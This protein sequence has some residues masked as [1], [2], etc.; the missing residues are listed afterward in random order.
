MIPALPEGVTARVLRPEPLAKGAGP[1]Q[2]GP[3]DARAVL[4]DVVERIELFSTH[5]PWGRKRLRKLRRGEITTKLTLGGS[6]LEPS[7]I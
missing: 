3:G 2:Q 5:K 7:G 6:H 4:R 1:W